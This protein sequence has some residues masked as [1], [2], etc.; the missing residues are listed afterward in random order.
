MPADAYVWLGF[1]A[2]DVAPSPN[3]QLYVNAAPS[4]SEDPALEKV[5][6]NG[7]LP[8]SGAPLAATTGGRFVAPPDGGFRPKINRYAAGKFVAEA[9]GFAGSNGGHDAFPHQLGL[10]LK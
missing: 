5:T 3:C 9:K 4:G 7:A 2:V 8:V 6:A 1:A 10:P